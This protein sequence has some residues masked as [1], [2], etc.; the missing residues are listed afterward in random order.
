MLATGKASAIAA[1]SSARIA[2]LANGLH[3]GREIGSVARQHR[4]VGADLRPARRRVAIGAEMIV[5]APVAHPLAQ[6]QQF[7]R[8]T[9]IAA[10]GHHAVERSEV[11]CTA[12]RHSPASSRM[13]TLGPLRAAKTLARPSVSP[14][15]WLSRLDLRIARECDEEGIRQAEID[16]VAVVLA[17]E[18][19]LQ[20][21]RRLAHGALNRLLAS[22]HRARERFRPGPQ[23][24]MQAALGG[25]RLDDA[26]LRDVRQQPQRAIKARLAAAVRAGHHIERAKPEPD[27]AQRSIA[28][29]GE[30]GD[31]D[32]RRV[33]AARD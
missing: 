25:E 15:H 22:L 13:R 19:E 16:G 26:A 20:A 7:G 32:V 4:R 24:R 3:R 21:D 17:G 12:C 23:C 9:R 2:D 33:R 30:L 1:S 18:A 10:M 14:V 31:H 29:N 27:V 28:G 11:R 5:K 8:V 6:Q